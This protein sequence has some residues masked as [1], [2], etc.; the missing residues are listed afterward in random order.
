MH[1]FTCKDNKRVIY[2]GTRKNA[3]PSSRGLGHRVFIPATRVRIP[4][5]MPFFLSFFLNAVINPCKKHSLTLTNKF[6][7]QASFFLLWN[8]LQLQKMGLLTIQR[9]AFASLRLF[10]G[11]RPPCRIPLEMPFFCLFS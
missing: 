2:Y 7:R 8:F 5:E 3:S 4:L 10:V 1:F 9:V 11:L 6:V